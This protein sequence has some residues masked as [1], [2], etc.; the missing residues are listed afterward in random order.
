MTNTIKKKSQRGFGQ[1]QRSL[2][3]A[4]R[5]ELTPA[6]TGADGATYGG[7]DSLDEVP[8]G[9]SVPV[10]ETSTINVH[11]DELRTLISAE[12]TKLA[13]QMNQDLTAQL[14]AVQAD[15]D[16]MARR[17]QQQQQ[18]L[19]E[20]AS[21]AKAEADRLK[22]VF[23]A[24]GHTIPAGDRSAGSSLGYN[25][26]RLILPSGQEPQGSARDFVD[27]LRNSGYTPRLTAY[28]PT[29][30]NSYE[31]VD[32]TYLDRFVR[33]NK[34]HL[35]RDMEV[36]MKAHGF[37]RGSSP[38]GQDAQAG[39]TLG[40]P[41]SVGSIVLDFLSSLM[42]DSHNP[43]YVWW[44]FVTTKLELGRVP[45][46]NILVPRFQW[47]D[48]P[49]NPEDYIL[50]TETSSANISSDS[51][52]LQTLTTPISLFGWGLGR[53]NR[54]GTRPIAIPEFINAS[55]LLDLIQ[56]VNTRLGQNFNALEDLVIR[57]IF[58]QTLA[59]PANIYY[60]NGAGI[61][62]TAG[63]LI[64]G[65]DGTANEEAFNQ[66]FGEMTRRQIPTFDNGSR[67]GVLNTVATAQFK[68][69]LGDKLRASTEA[70][71]QEVTN[72]L[73]AGTLGDGIVRPNG[74]LGTYCNFMLFESGT[75]AVGGAGTDGVNTITTGAGGVTMR[76]NYFF[77]PGVAGEGVSLPMEIRMDDSGTFGTKMRFI[78]RYI[79]GWGSL[80]C[81]STNPGQQ[82]RVV[83]LRNTDVSL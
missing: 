5:P 73:N 23:A 39:N 4:K 70:E 54:I 71:I 35:M 56:P 25:V 49:I 66:L 24:T 57:Q 46:N 33:A 14:Q 75:T 65:S 6:A 29:D 10:Q 13:A 53:G 11:P 27:I 62:N 51:Q 43:R 17:T 37:L 83:V 52:A 77:G 38:S 45:G 41:G 22:S 82:D 61:T 30:G 72:I 9:A 1:D 78:W 47:I 31:Q 55:S 36:L 60:S 58:A 59:N 74:Y 26:N 63:D 79:G 81:T 67:V 21:K 8:E 40:T 3:L 20:E 2:I 44:Q 28:D 69:S 32:T 18:E 80:D 34:S 76:D 42:R 68:N 7:T 48:E 12:A 64:V 50:D 15:V 16:A 19:Q